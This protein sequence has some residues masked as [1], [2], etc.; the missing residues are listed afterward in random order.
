MAGKEI[1]NKMKDK[2]T[3]KMSEEEIELIYARGCFLFGQLKPS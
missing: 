1:Y 2:V 3:E